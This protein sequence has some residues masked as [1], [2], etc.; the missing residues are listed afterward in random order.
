[1]LFFKSPMHDGS[2]HHQRI[3]TGTFQGGKI[4]VKNIKHSAERKV[5]Q[6]QVGQTPGVVY[7]HFI[8]IVRSIAVFP[9]MRSFVRITFRPWLQTTLKESDG[10]GKRAREGII[11]STAHVSHAEETAVAFDPQGVHVVHRKKT[12]SAADTQVPESSVEK[13]PTRK[14]RAANAISLVDPLVTMAADPLLYLL[15]LLVRRFLLSQRITTVD[16]FLAS[17][18]REMAI[19]LIKWRKRERLEERAY[20]SA[21]NELRNWKHE[22][23]QRQETRRE[24]PVGLP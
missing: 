7:C 9:W 12:H 22:V 6:L 10:I 23:Q 21:M 1:M 17:E 15:G 11:Y 2:A 19:A 3:L 16:T 14:K 13:E 24:M 8:S 4:A 18:N 20:S 5:R